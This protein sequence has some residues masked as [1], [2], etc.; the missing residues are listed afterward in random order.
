MSALQ[1]DEAAFW[2][3]LVAYLTDPRGDH[4]DLKRSGGNTRSRKFKAMSDATVRMVG[5]RL[6]AL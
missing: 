6:G 4:V 3:G 1:T 2:V 5:K